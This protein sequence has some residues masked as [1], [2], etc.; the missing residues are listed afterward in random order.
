MSRD[1][2]VLG[3]IPARGGSKGLPG[4][5]IR[6]LGGKPLLAYTA[7]TARA[8]RNLARIV[9]STEDEAIAAVGRECGLEVPFLRPAE[10]ARDDTPMLPV[11][12]HAVAE[13]E[14]AEPERRVDAVCLLQPTTPFRQATDIDACID[15]LEQR[16]A[17]TVITVRPVPSV[18]NPHWVFFADSQGVL[19][20]STGEATPIPS[21]QAL[22]PAFHRDGAV[23]VIR[24]ATLDQNRL[25]GSVIVGVVAEGEAYVNIDGADDWARAEALVD[26]RPTVGPR[27]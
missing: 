18:Y 11:V 3:L 24:R 25:F 12:R 26:A 21:R 15:L 2:R 22:P 9:L 8:A 20:L 14:R 27:R 6:L 23:Y 1:M 19:R 4:K 16:Q 5:N 7:E 13:L 10:L 17:D